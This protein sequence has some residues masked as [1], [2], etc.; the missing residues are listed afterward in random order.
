M[1]G[2]DM[3]NILARGLHEAAMTYDEAGCYHKTC[4]MVG[5]FKFYREFRRQTDFFVV[6]IDTE[7]VLHINI[8]GTDGEK[9][10]DKIAAWLSNFYMDRDSKGRHKGFVEAAQWAMDRFEEITDLPHFD[11]VVIN[12]HSRGTGI[13]PHL[14][15]MLAEYFERIRMVLTKPIEVFLFALV[16][17]F[18]N[19]GKLVTWDAAHDRYGITGYAVKNP[20]DAACYNMRGKGDDEGCD[21]LR[22]EIELPVDSFVQKILRW[23]KFSA[24]EHSPKEYADGLVIFCKGNKETIAFLKTSRKMMVN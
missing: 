6:F 11:S 17:T 18:T 9:W 14:A 13:A 21:V 20:R 22:C 4:I 7:N 10:R 23:F 19:Y 24:Y 3:I 1:E 8:R 16:P 2:S 5:P 12:T 15:I